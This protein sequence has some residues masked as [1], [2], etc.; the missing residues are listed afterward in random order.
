MRAIAWLIRIL[1]FLLFLGFALEN[2]E[3]VMIN[4]FLGYYLEAPLVAVLLGMLLLGCLVGVLLMLPG[5]LRVR[6]EAARL[7]QIEIDQLNILRS[8]YVKAR[9]R[10][11]TMAEFIENPMEP[12]Q[13]IID[14]ISP[15]ATR[16]LTAPRCRPSRPPPRPATF[17]A[18]PPS[19][20]RP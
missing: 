13:M 4:F 5:L 9:V 10:I 19:P 6:R 2:T 15:R 3:P 17:P 14:E 8:M 18:P 1:V 16:R 20:T 7:Q 11:W 12:L